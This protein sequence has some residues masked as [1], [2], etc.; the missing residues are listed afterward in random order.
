MPMPD[1]L[2]TPSADDLGTAEVTRFRR[3]VEREVDRQLPDYHA[4]WR[5]SVEDVSAFWELVWRY[6]GFTSVTPYDRVLDGAMPAARWFHGAT[7]NYAE[8]V[9]RHETASRPALIVCGE[10]E[11]PYEISWAQLR[12]Q[13][14]G[15]AATFRALG[16]RPGDR[17]AGYV[18]NRPEAVVALLASAAVGAIWSS[19]SPDFGIQAAIAR[20]GQLRPKLLVAVGSYSFAGKGFDRAS[21]VKALAGALE[22]LD[23]TIAI[24]GRAEGIPWREAVAD[25]A[26][27]TFEATPFDHP[28]W[29]L[30]SS[31]TT[32]AP[33][34][35]VHGHGGI[36][37]EH[38]K[39]LALGHGLS[40][41]DRL[42]FLSSTSWMV[43]NYLVGAP[44]VGATPVL[45]DG[46]PTIPDVIG[47]WRV[48]AATGATVAGMGAAYITA[49][50]KRDSS[51]AS[52]VD[53]SALRVVV[54]TGSPLPAR[55]WRWL[56]ERLPGVRIDSS[57][58]GTDV[59][60]AFVCGSPALPVH[61]GEIP[62]RAL[63]V[64]AE[65]W[66]AAGQPVVNEVGELVVTE[67]MPSMPV[68]FWDDDDGSRYRESYF[69]TFPGVWR[70]GDWIRISSR[71]TVVIEGRSDSTLNKAGVRMGSA[72]IY[73]A[74]ESL[75]GVADSLVVG[76]ELPDGGY[77]MPLFV[78]RADGA[79]L[80]G[81]L[82]AEIVDAIRT[83]LSP[84][85]VP[86]ELVQA[87]AIPRTK[88][89]K[90]LEVPIK[91]LLQGLSLCEVVDLETVDDATAMHWFADF[92]ARRRFAVQPVKS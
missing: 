26:E 1:V 40:S 74:V 19:C 47:S 20:F 6:F 35:I 82:E 2:W 22:S 88:T 56:A 89:G 30:F 73:S 69:A 59:C 57:S 71:G 52:E 24:D 8:Q 67:P 33:K 12:R 55:G 5:W 84:R 13:V 27:L 51:P 72:D 61:L 80:D 64:K 28:L 54:S 23:A 62:A 25:D 60:S 42:Y 4:L 86:D 92:A 32:G 45:Y 85:H 16:V 18:T 68:R 21:E 83:T 34:G 50:E 36:V 77:Y 46:S 48:A 41:G 91:R 29:V 3:W 44:L 39:S 81:D 78:V 53:L 58:G 66:N 79:E 75:E 63:G 37:L 10:N 43:W 11:P 15:L 17:V 70:H 65:A 76:V 90:K 31:G 9:F 38:T 14:A 7:L 87:P 49:C